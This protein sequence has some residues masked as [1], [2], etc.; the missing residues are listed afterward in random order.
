MS[1]TLDIDSACSSKALDFPG[2]PIS[3]SNKIGEKTRS[4]SSKSD[5]SAT[6]NKI[7]DVADI[8][9]T[10]ATLF[11]D[12]ES[13][14]SFLHYVRVTIHN[15]SDESNELVLSDAAFSNQ[16]LPIIVD[17]DKLA[18]MLRNGPVTMVFTGTGNIPTASTSTTTTF[19][20]GVSAH[21]SK[22]IGDISKH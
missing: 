19:C 21:S 15:D 4:V 3:I 9:V 8:H 16:N 13:D 6:L 5:M 20:I 2:V 17:K 10:T 22:S 11:I 1:A 12:S 18:T 7:A 14:L